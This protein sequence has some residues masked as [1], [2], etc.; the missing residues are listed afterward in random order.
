MALGLI[1]VV[2]LSGLAGDLERSIRWAKGL[3]G[4]PAESDAAVPLGLT[5]QFRHDVL[6]RI[7]GRASEIGS[8]SGGVRQVPLLD[9][10][11]VPLVEGHSLP[12]PELVWG[13][14][15]GAGFVV[16]GLAHLL[17]RGLFRR[18]RRVI[19]DAALHQRLQSL[20]AHVG[21][22][23][24]LR[25]FESPN[26]TG[27]V[28][29]GLLRPT[30]G[31]PCEFTQR[32][33]PA[34]Q[35][36]MLAHELAHLAGNDPF[37]QAVADAV[38]CLLWWHPV[39][40][41][42]RFR[43]RAA[44]ELAAD[45]ASLL[46]PAGPEVLAECLVQLAGQVVRRQSLGGI[47]ATGPAYRSGLGKRIARL[48]NLRGRTW[49]P[50]PRAHR[51]ICKTVWPIALIMAA[52][53]SA[54]WARPQP[55]SKS[56]RTIGQTWKRSL[57]TLGLLA[58]L[59]TEAAELGG[60]ASASRVRTEQ[61]A[62]QPIATT[63]L[64]SDARLLI[65]MGKLQLAE[66]KLDQALR[67][68]PAN[69]EAIRYLGQIKNLREGQAEPKR[70]PSSLPSPVA[71][72]LAEP[73]PVLMA[74]ADPVKPTTAPAAP[75]EPEEPAT[76]P[77]EASSQPAFR[78]DPALMRRY[79]LSPTHPAPPGANAAQ[80]RMSRGKQQIENKLNGIVLNEVFY[81]GIPL[82]EVIKDLQEE[83]RKRDPARQGLNFLMSN[84]PEGPTHTGV[85][86]ATGLPIP[87]GNV[88]LA[89]VI[90]RL[91]LRD[92]RLKDVLD[93]L[94]RVADQPIKY[95]VED[96]GVVLAPGSGPGFW[97]PASGR[98]G[99]PARLVVRTFRVDTNTFLPGLENAF[100]ITIASGS[101]SGVASANDRTESKTKASTGRDVQQ[102]MRTLLHQLGVSMD[103]PN[104]SVFYNELTGILMVRAG[105][106]DLE[107]VQAAI[108]TLGGKA[109]R[110]TP[111]RDGA[112]A[113][114]DPERR[115][116]GNQ[117]F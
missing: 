101:G 64:V 11:E 62:P 117:L 46:L 48:I 26:L 105:E 111:G 50:L 10:V 12:W 91:K 27:P 98:A 47:A 49:A 73:A 52:V 54:G 2:Q 34:Q 28:A 19:Q 9:V 66:S 29:F 102:A 100:G 94:T 106:E 74:A 78:M 80:G 63:S 88:D 3:L 43:L 82:V 75:A 81:D 97:P 25:V 33:S 68:D 40:W 86:P 18:Q 31:L 22:R 58:A 87:S 53:L 30:I 14:G 104:K 44:A 45:E 103:G 76:A 20:S 113:G 109:L 95:T 4:S 42:A 8:Q 96:Y 57:A 59:P 107:L 77:A 39:V 16:I 36:A 65:E 21:F 32:F 93:A 114:T 116:G 83:A 5:D 92:V 67:R 15:A 69:G 115:S 71:V 24:R 38:A 17:F 51:N 84:V 6:D 56:M 13:V 110:P 60:T 99:E 7:A 37:G 1:A 70:D 89:N 85:D 108:E 23:G 61:S 72:D 79:G 112:A 90:V 55:E 35:D 41:W